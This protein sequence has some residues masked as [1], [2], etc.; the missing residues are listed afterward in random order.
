MADNQTRYE[1]A[2]RR[3][4]AYNAAEHWRRAFHMFHAALEIVPQ[5]PEAYAGLGEACFGLRMLDHALE[6]YKMA[7]RYSRGD[8]RY[9]E[10]VADLQ[11]RLGLLSE[12]AKTYMAAGELQLRQRQLEQSV[13]NWERAVRLEPALLGA[14][15]R[16]AMVHQRQDNVRGAVRECLAIARIL[17]D[18]GQRGQALKMCHAALRLDPGNEDALMAIKL[19]QEGA[20]AVGEEE[21]A[22]EEA[23]TP[24]SPEAEVAF[25]EAPRVPAVEQL[26]LTE[27]EH[28]REEMADTVRQIATVFEEERRQWQQKQQPQAPADPLALATQRAQNELAEEI[29]RDEEGEA[30]LY[31]VGP[32]G[33]SKLERDALIGQGM[34]FQSRGD[35]ANAI[36]CYEKAVAGGLRLPAAFFT[37][38]L[39]YLQAG[40]RRHAR[41]AFLQAGRD[42]DYRAPAKLAMAEAR[43]GE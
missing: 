15:R 36:A 14:H 39:L 26:E 13:F 10:K 4:Q 2:L 27:E 35:V 7:A 5:A 9:L 23:V 3:G 21:P 42:H 37:L 11:E 20:A 41:A 6:S 32:E 17:Q 19:V 30:D 18:R 34:D 25:E 31:G 16:L 22:R 40:K 33:L 12:A 29:F 38:G 8:L 43:E 24:E 28:E 1:E